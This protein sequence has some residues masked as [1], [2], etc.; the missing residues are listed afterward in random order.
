MEYQIITNQNGMIELRHKFLNEFY[1]D[2]IEERKELM[3]DLNMLKRDELVGKAYQKG[4]PVAE[5]E[6]SLDRELKFEELEQMISEDGE[7]IDSLVPSNFGQCNIC[8][9]HS[10]CLA[11]W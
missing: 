1:N 8:L 10:H 9:G 2:N 6:C 4:F 7:K 11:K 3:K 5:I